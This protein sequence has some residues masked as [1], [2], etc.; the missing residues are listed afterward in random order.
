MEVKYIG[1]RGRFRAVGEWR[2][3]GAMAQDWRVHKGASNEHKRRQARAGGAFDEL[4]VKTCA[5]NVVALLWWMSDGGQAST[6]TCGT[7]AAC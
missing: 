6:A 1:G 7:C 5:C 4:C 2:E 3:T